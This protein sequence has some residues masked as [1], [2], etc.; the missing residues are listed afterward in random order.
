ME[1]Y[2]QIMPLIQ[3]AAE[4]LSTERDRGSRF[5]CVAH[6]D[7]DGMVAAG[8]LGA[9]LKGSKATINYKFSYA[10][11][12]KVIT[13][14]DEDSFDILVFVDSGSTQLETILR[15]YPSKKIV[16]ID[17][18]KTIFDPSEEKPS[19][20]HVNPWLVGI[21]GTL[22]ICAG[23]L[24]YLI[25]K[26]MGNFDHLAP[27]AIVAAIAEY[28]DSEGRL[29]GLN[30]LI[31]EE[32][33]D[34][35]LLKR[36]NDI[37]LLGRETYSLYNMLFISFPVLPSLTTKSDEC[38]YFIKDLGLNENQTWRDLTQDQKLRFINKLKERM[39]KVGLPKSAIENLSG[40]V[41]TLTKEKEGTMRRDAREFGF[42]LNACA[43]R[44]APLIGLGL[45]TEGDNEKYEQAL[46]LF[47]DD[48]DKLFE[49]INEVRNSRKDFSENLEYVYSDKIEPK[50]VGTVCT[51]VLTSDLQSCSKTLVCMAKE[52]DQV[53][54]SAR[55]HMA[56]ARKE[57]INVGSALKAAAKKSEGI[58][59][60]HDNSAGGF[61]KKARIQ[62]FLKS[63]DEELKNQIKMKRQLKL[64]DF[65]E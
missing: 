56:A 37:R 14:L 4:F 49:G 45:I 57:G 39:T 32:S 62:E 25:V 17:H 36:N 65:I 63:L 30:S 12:E 15:I 22:S 59:G 29:E 20:I 42:M 34:K 24:A 11:N 28:Q 21:S 31:L 58:G 10:I 55:C 53:K 1:R 64:T 7:A 47:K 13:S 51:M 60:G 44:N 18:H 6:H 35:G 40:D 61:I 16:I 33:E 46:Q 54:L 9:A 38:K 5:F 19:L 2:Q 3:K 23:G 48:T 41:Y 50:M 27:F 8:I 43:R 52:D 26:E